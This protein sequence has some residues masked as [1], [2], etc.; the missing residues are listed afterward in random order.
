MYSWLSTSNASHA[1]PADA[2][3]GSSSP[4]SPGAAQAATNFPSASST[5][6]S[7][8]IASDTA[9][10]TVYRVPSH[11]VRQFSRTLSRIASPSVAFPTFTLS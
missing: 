4:S 6:P 1:S 7:A 2:D 3:A 11:V 8:A 10:S 5:A 9:P